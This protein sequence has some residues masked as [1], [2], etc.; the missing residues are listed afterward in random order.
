M[1][2][3]RIGF[4][5]YQNLGHITY[6]Q[7]MRA[8][9]A[10]HPEIQPT[11]MPI[12]TWKEDQ[13]QRFPIIRSNQTLSNGLRARDLLKCQTGQFDA[14]FCHTQEAAVLLGNYMKD[15][16]TILSLDATSININSMA[17]A[18]GL[19][20]KSRAFEYLKHF[21]IE[22][23][24]QKAAHLMPWSHWVE[25]SLIND[26]H[27]PKRKI[28]VNPPG[29]DL[30]HWSVSEDERDSS[31]H[32]S[33]RVLFVG[34]DFWRKGGETLI[35]SAASMQG[36]WIVDVVTNESIPGA[37]GIANFHVH[38]GLKAG[39]PEL[40][41]LFRIAN[42]FV[43]PTLGDCFSLV[44]M[45]AMAMRLPV[46]TTRVGALS[47]ILIDG[48]TGLFIPP[49]SPEKLTEAICELGKDPVRRR[50]MGNAGRRHAEQHFD[51][52]KSYSKLI[53]LIKSVADARPA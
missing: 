38:R 1:K 37:E 8:E 41:A 51:G 36:K 12:P 18:Y 23:S 33:L 52:A 49:N 9:V 29:L 43:L 2:T 35:R 13:W 28:T 34:G 21:L 32:L 46:V 10:K 31:E 25:E 30:E 7:A 45:E 16:P 20:K 48:E 26:Y 24:F 22:R 47:E 3:Y 17:G 4:L 44:I 42:I 40:L 50:K 11:W 14:L 39:T 19:K 5:M 27:V 15:I 6:D 53:A